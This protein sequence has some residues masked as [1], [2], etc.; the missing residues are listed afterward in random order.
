M[1]VSDI[2][3]QFKISNS[4]PQFELKARDIILSIAKRNAEDRK[5]NIDK[6]DDKE[7]DFVGYCLKEYPSMSMQQICEGVVGFIFAPPPKGDGKDVWNG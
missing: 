4:K 2:I 3:W 7:N 1:D 5:Q 6:T